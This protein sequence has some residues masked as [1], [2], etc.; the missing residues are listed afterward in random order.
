MG[1]QLESLAASRL[2]TQLA[3][4]S[5]Y[6]KIPLTPEGS[7]KTAFISADTT[8]QFTRMPFGLSG[9]IDEFNRLMHN[10]LGPLCG[11]IMRNYLD[12]MIIDGVDWA[13]VLLKLRTVLDKL[14]CA[15]LTLK[16][17]K[18]FFGSRRIEFLGFV[19]ENGQIQSGL[20]KI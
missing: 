9:A 16:L 18:C 15:R 2:F 7:A 1:K 6:L 8:G 3:L 12:N 4:A 13:E 14:R 10:M 20:E 19:I 11:M 5:G 17:S